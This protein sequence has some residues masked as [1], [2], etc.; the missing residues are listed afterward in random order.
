[1]LPTL[2]KSGKAKMP[3]LDLDSKESEKPSISFGMLFSDR[4]P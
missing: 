3:K 4:T 1:M 2:V